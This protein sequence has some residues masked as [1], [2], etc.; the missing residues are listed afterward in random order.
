MN[1]ATEETYVPPP[2]SGG[3][4]I[5]PPAVLAGHSDSRRKSPLLATV[6][7]M[8]P[9]LGQVYVGYYQRGF[10]HAVVVAT[11]ITLLVAGIGPLIPLGALFLAF[12]WLY[13]LVDAG[14]RAALYNEALAGREGIEL[15]QDLSPA[16]LG[17]S[18]AGGVSMAFVGIVL[19][20]HTRFDVP[21]D[22]LE[23]WWPAALIIFGGY[24]VYRAREESAERRSAALDEQ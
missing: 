5:P 12:F 20:L 3:G 14:R 13:N 24:L 18:L 2:L 23:E 16:A 22:W 15:P 8:M 21:L 1:E 11:L 9:G 17:G 4:A 6:L 7:S 10:V 19:L